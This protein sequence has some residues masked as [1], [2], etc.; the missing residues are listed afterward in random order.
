[1]V[2]HTSKRG[3]SSWDFRWCKV[4]GVFRYVPALICLGMVDPASQRTQCDTHVGLS[5]KVSLFSGA[6]D[7]GLAAIVLYLTVLSVLAVEV[8]L[9]DDLSPCLTTLST[10]STPSCLPKGS[11]HRLALG[12]DSFVGF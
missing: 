7:G 6:T 5:V 9:I 11:S 2:E 3:R 8:V 12:A 10:T 1:V 4:G